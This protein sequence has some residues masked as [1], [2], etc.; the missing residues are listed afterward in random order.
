VVRLYRV[1]QSALPDAV[2]AELRAEFRPTY[3]YLAEQGI[4]AYEKKSG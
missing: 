3:R 4:D 1:N 2:A